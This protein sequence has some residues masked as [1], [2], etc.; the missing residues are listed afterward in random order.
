MALLP[1]SGL[2]LLVLRLAGATS[3]VVLSFGRRRRR[4]NARQIAP[5]SFA[6]YRS[7]ASSRS[8]RLALGM[9]EH[10]KSTCSLIWAGPSL[11]S[12]RQYVVV[13]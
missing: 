9:F 2:R 7:G 11:E 3:S 13:A 10:T 6:L 8:P 4:R 1:G 5:G 12:V